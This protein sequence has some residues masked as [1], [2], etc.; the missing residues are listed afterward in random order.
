MSVTLEPVKISDSEWEIM[1]VVWTLQSATAQEIIE[2]LG[3][4]K[5]WK[6]ATI[7][8]LLGRLV[9]KEA[10][11]TEQEG[12]KYIYHPNV[13]EAET[14]QSAT[15]NLFSHI[16]AKRIGHTIGELIEQA[17]L[18]EKD[19]A[20]IQ[21]QLADKQPVASIQCNCIPG[22]CECKHHA[23]STSTSD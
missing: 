19:I 2:V 23:S 13:S 7:K 15:E 11:R 5:D 22:Q 14:V 4:S 9:K 18:T 20:F 8:T 1:R 21:Q 3:E 12:K 10:L 17:D 6:P 16:C